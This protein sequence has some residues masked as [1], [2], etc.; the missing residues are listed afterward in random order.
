MFKPVRENK[1]PL[2]ENVALQIETLILKGNLKAGDKLPPERKLVEIF[3]VSRTS[4]REAVQALAAKGLVKVEHGRGIFVSHVSALE[5]NID[6]PIAPNLFSADGDSMKDLYEIRK[7]VETKA[8]AWAAVRRTPEE[9]SKIMHCVTVL[10]EQDNATLQ[11]YNVIKAWEFDTQFHLSIMEATH[12][13]VLP[14]IMYG[15]LDLLAESRRSTLKVEGRLLRSVQEHKVIAEAICA[16]D[17]DAAEHLMFQHLHSVE[18][19][20]MKIQKGIK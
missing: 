7:L 15:L 11:S 12:N 9:A 5:G 19:E 10:S 16:G 13:L 20:L 3:G 6:M 2:Y 14:R 8:A 18:M 17:A 4:V 1:R